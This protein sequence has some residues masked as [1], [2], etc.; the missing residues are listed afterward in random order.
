MLSS[1]ATRAVT[2]LAPRLR[3]YS[4]PA[5]VSAIPMPSRRCPS[6]TARRYILPRQPSQA[7]IRAPTISLSRSATMRAAGEFAIRR[8][9]SAKRSAVLACSLRPSAHSSRT[10]LAS[11]CR[12]RRI[13]NRSSAKS[14]VWQ[15]LRSTRIAPP[16]QAFGPALGPLA[17]SRQV[18]PVE[19]VA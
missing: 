5:R 7:A 14:A 6:R 17:N 12:H 13:V 8:S 10:A 4:S 3:R 11:S 9:T 1:K 18:G 2:R 15:S 16:K 19:R